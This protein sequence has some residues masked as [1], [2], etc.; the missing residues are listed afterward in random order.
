MDEVTLT[1]SEVEARAIVELLGQLPT[2]QS[3][4]PLWVKLREQYEAQR[5]AT[6]PL[7]S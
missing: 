5:Q 1:M 6:P 4:Y 3:A 7:P 2:S